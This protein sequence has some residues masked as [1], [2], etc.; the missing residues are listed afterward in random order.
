LVPVFV[1]IMFIVTGTTFFVMIN[2]QQRIIEH[3]AVKIAEIV[4]RQAL[5]GRSVYT[6]VVADKLKRDG[7]GPDI[8]SDEKPG[9]VPLPAQ[10]LKLVGSEASQRSDG[11]YRYRP[12]S[13]WNLEPTQGLRDEF[14]NW[15]WRQLEAQ[16]AAQPNGPITW[17]AVWRI[18]SVDDVRTLRYVRA[19]PASSSSCVNCHNHYEGLA[20]TQALRTAAGVPLG[21]QWQQHQLLG[22]FEVSIPVDRVE[23]IA[24]GQAQRTLWLVVGISLIGLTIAAWYA[25]RDARRKQV[26]AAEFEY[27][28]R[29]DA[30]TGLANRNQFQDSARH[31]LSRA[32]RD[33]RVV[34][35][36]FVDIDHFK[37]INDSL[38]HQF[39]DVVLKEI[40]QRLTHALREVDLVARHSGDEFTILLHGEAD[41]LNLARVARKVLQLISQP[42][43][44]DSHELFMS[45]SVGISCFPQDGLEV[46]TL[47]KNADIAM[48]RAKEFGRNHFEFFS[49]DM[50]TR[51]LE[52]LSIT[53]RLRQAVERDQL[54][55]YYQPRVNAKSGAI[56]GVEALV[57]WQ[58]PELGLLEPQRFI[59][60]AEDTG[61]IE[62]IGRWVLT[63]ACEQVRR[64]DAAGVPSVPMAVNLSTR[65]F[66]ATDMVEMVGG[67][68]RGAGI[69]PHRLELEITE[70]VLMQQPQAAEMVLARLNEMGVV[71]AIDDFGTGY[72]S[73]SYLKRF[74][75]DYLKI[76]KSFIDGLPGDNNDRVITGAIISL[77]RNLNVKVVAE[78]VETDE[79][80]R[81][82]AGLGCDELQGFLFARPAPADDITPLLR[83]GRL[84]R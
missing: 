14:Q 74:P 2:S 57:R 62:S 50:N 46:E 72:S 19:D 48:Y 16:D 58:H 36:L 5:A 3:E 26:L 59:R 66:R 40:A 47:L 29:Y 31:A 51:A 76:D 6:A 69:H 38:G 27:Q 80:Q 55:L 15:A 13:K 28:A 71:I 11:L 65:Q 24:R 64:W 25:I 22:A 30:L 21:K 63:A 37:R 79:Q 39:G 60:H 33:S 10:F 54:L 9:H 53:N 32:T 42:M 56:T 75:I 68:I 78:G 34:G 20:Q 45:A 18:E 67:I 81:F 82:L 61:V 43:Q 35:L 73:L 8:A 77:A 70:S 4:A 52:T 17:Q 1:L 49:A 83:R 7:F 12:L 44:L 41:S 23:E 84:S